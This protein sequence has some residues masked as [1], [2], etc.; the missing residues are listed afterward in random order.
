MFYLMSL[1]TWIWI[2]G[3]QELTVATLQIPS[4]LFCSYQ[5]CC[6]PAREA[7]QE[8][9]WAQVKPCNLW[10]M[11]KPLGSASTTE[12]SPSRK[13]V[14]ITHLHSGWCG[15]KERSGTGTQG[16]RSDWHF[17]RSRTF[18]IPLGPSW[19]P[20]RLISR[21]LWLLK[22]ISC[23][24]WV[25]KK[26]VWVEL[27]KNDRK[28]LR[29]WFSSNWIVSA[30]SFFQSQAVCSSLLRVFCDSGN[31]GWILCWIHYRCRLGLIRA[32]LSNC[33]LVISVPCLIHYSPPGLGD[34]WVRRC[35]GLP[36]QQQ[37]W[38]CTTANPEEFTGKKTEGKQQL[39]NKQLFFSQYWLY[40]GYCM[41][42]VFFML[43]KNG[44][45]YF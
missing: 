44:Y 22:G 10:G 42:L 23:L 11:P 36:P 29:L 2:T 7:G 9:F 25:K 18:C 21:S 16:D 20:S 34:K 1:N 33:P 6:R 12:W 14:F 26:I 40:Y 27:P 19:D 15:S 38:A 43:L 24:S 37:L 5:G 8:L 39:G 45:G 3:T 4:L 31:I 17:C 35:K 32:L 30:S 28:I 41:V 13:A